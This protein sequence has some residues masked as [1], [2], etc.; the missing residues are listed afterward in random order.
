MVGLFLTLPLL[1]SAVA[2]AG[3]D[4]GLSLEWGEV[5]QMPV[6][7]SPAPPFVKLRLVNR[8]DRDRTLHI[9]KELK[10][11]FT[12]PL[13]LRVRLRV[14]GESQPSDE[15]GYVSKQPEKGP[16]WGTTKSKLGY[17][18]LSLPPGGVEEIAFSLP[19]VVDRPPTAELGPLLVQARLWLLE[20]GS[21]G[22][23]VQLGPLETGQ[24]ELSWPSPSA[25]ANTS[26][27]P[28]R[29]LVLSTDPVSGGAAVEAG[30][31]DIVV[32]FDRPMD[33]SSFSFTGGGP[34]F[35]TLR[36]KPVWRSES[37]C[38]LPVLLEADREYVIGLNGPGHEGFRSARGAALLPD[39]LTIR[40]LSIPPAHRLA[41]QQDSVT[42]LRELIATRYSYR[43]LRFPDFERRWK[44]AEPE[45]RGDL[46][47]SPRVFGE[48]A[49][50]LLA[51][52]EDPHIWL[53]EGGAIIPSYRRSVSLTADFLRV[54][55][56]LTEWKQPHQMVAR[57]VAPGG[58]GYLAIHSWEKRYVELLP[59]ALQALTDLRDQPALILD[60]RANQGGDETLA[61]AFAGC[62]VRERVHY[63][64]HVTVDSAAPG[65]FTA[66]VKRWLE[67]NRSGPE[68]RGKIIVLMG[69][70]N[71]SAAESFLL[72]MRQVPDTRFVGERSTGASGNPLPHRLANG[73]TVHLPSWKA[74]LPDGSEWEGRGIGPDV[75]VP[76]D[77]DREI[78]PVLAKALE[79]VR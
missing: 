63:A 40:T 53:E 9:P 31:R 11:G 71:M 2:A 75:E 58:I 66:P 3:D 37:V 73:V 19:S 24:R 46:A 68:Y 13:S 28:A 50:R 51:A 8:S 26:P 64:G 42:Q 27:M 18:V 38:V 1:T 56:M 5:V 79:L 57:G 61:Q 47:S 60:V 43:V 15:A 44:E 35:P 17:S 62:F 32:E 48:I 70:L 36:G 49:A 74:L 21:D 39:K 41:S 52:T 16:A 76:W 25:P 33:R 7:Y 77:A 67:P 65:G 12:V 10:D 6:T 29:P 59:A 45:L 14:P 55:R 54:A 30:P 72:M 34:T 4:I 69:P 23:W 22:R 20:R 78:D